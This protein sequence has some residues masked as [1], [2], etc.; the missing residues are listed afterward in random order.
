MRQQLQELEDHYI[1]GVDC[2]SAPARQQI[3]VGIARYLLL[4]IRDLLTGELHLRAMSL[5]HTTLLSIAPL[6]G[7]SFSILEGP[8]VQN[9]LGDSLQAALAPLGRGRGSESG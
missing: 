6:L 5:V 4:L 3:G 9:Q 7:L 8:D 2:R 1:W